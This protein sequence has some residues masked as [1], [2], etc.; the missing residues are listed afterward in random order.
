ME[1]NFNPKNPLYIPEIEKIHN[2]N[3]ADFIC[4]VNQ[5]TNSDITGYDSLYNFSIT[6]IE[7]FW[8]LIWKY[9]R[10]KHSASY[11]KILYY[12]FPINE[13]HPG[14]NWFPDARF[15]FAENLLRN[16]SND[17]AL[18]SYN[19]SANSNSISYNELYNLTF[20]LSSYFRQNGIIPG[21]R[22]AALTTNIPESVIGMLAA[23]S[24]GAVWSST[25][26]DFGVQGIADRFQQIE[27][28]VLITVDGYRYNG[29]VI[30]I[31]ET[32]NSLKPYLPSD[33]LLI[34][35]P[36]VHT[37]DEIKQTLNS[38]F[39]LINNIL[40]QN[41][42]GD[43][44][45]EQLPFNHPVYIMY[46]SGTTGKPK[47]IVHGA[48]GTLLQ[49]FKELVLHTD[50][51]P[52]D[53]ISYFTT[54]GW[55]MWNWLV[56]SLITGAKIFLYDG[57]PAYPS[58]EVLWKAIDKFK[59]NIFGTSPKFLSAVQ[60]TGYSPMSDCD[61]SSLRTILST[62]SPLS[63]TNFE[64]VYSNVKR[65]VMLSSIAG[66]T[67]I[68]SCFMLGNPMLPVYSEEIQCRGLGMAIE[69][70]D[71]NG[72]QVIND[73]GEL[74]CTKI[75]PSMPIYFWNDGDGMLY[76]NAYF[77]HYPKTWRHGDYVRITDRGTVIMYGR[78]DATL[79]PGGVRIGTSEIYRTLEKMEE[80]I[81][82]LA[83]GLTEN[84][85]VSVVLFV[86]LKSGYEFNED[87]EKAI[88]DLIKKELTPRH[89]P[90]HIRQI[91]EI[92]VTLNGKKV[93]TAVT[94]I[95]T[96]KE[97]SN[98]DALLNPKSLEQFLGMKF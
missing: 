47:C 44:D 37:E 42:T 43:I 14:A 31:L 41:L 12:D 72:K 59:I 65:N 33:I 89:I 8:E 74:V 18:I 7:A 90:K 40:N 16:R 3:I 26:P 1:L 23:T 70:W 64:W 38:E 28:K 13:V 10:I 68:I 2:S 22:I 60:Q 82:S 75:F 79:N 30:S 62:G 39:V 92:P 87:M 61:L 95:L 63:I 91:S 55:M 57:S 86:V 32:I 58:I 27:P 25:S 45:F 54:C 56:S 85:D 35:V 15:N 19:E 53:T 5:E 76:K 97:V 83:V 69:S 11:S 50:L 78:S 88:R 51:K 77:D 34:V 21:D 4:F 71:D 80:I 98:K 17:T 81:D 24:I 20:R 52:D 93:E 46:S 66:G 36:Q 73:Q 67:D 48:G 94:K 84:N 29:K 49:H 9:A 6:E 96:G